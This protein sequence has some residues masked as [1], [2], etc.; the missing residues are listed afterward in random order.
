MKK[1]WKQIIA[2]TVLLFVS[3][4]IYEVVSLKVE[5]LA[6]EEAATT[7]K[8][9]LEDL[10]THDFAGAHTLLDTPQQ[11]TITLAA[12]QVAEEQIEKKHGEPRGKPEVC[13]YN[14]NL[15]LTQARF[16]CCND[17]QRDSEYIHVTLIKRTIGWRIRE[18]RYDFG[19]A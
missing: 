16:F 9:F 10:N 8:H 4:I 6:L 13:E 7:A 15:H 19:P 2:G 14:L 5:S 11:R 12:M 18:Y 17:Y 1:V 3:L